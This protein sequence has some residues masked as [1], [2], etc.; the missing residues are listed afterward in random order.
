MIAAAR[1]DSVASIEGLERAVDLFELIDTD[2]NEH[3]SFDEFKA[4]V[5]QHPIL[6]RAC[7]CVHVLVCCARCSSAAAVAC[8]LTTAARGG[9]VAWSVTAGRGVSG[10]GAPIAWRGRR[11]RCS[12]GH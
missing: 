5:V 4:A 9:G 1:P 7:I 11:R 3:I 6:V 12:E 8:R 2:H 10:A